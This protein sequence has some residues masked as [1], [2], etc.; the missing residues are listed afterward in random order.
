M[1][2]ILAG[3]TIFSPLAFLILVVL[4]LDV[5]KTKKSSCRIKITNLTKKDTIEEAYKFDDILS[6]YDVISRLPLTNDVNLYS[7]VSIDN[8][9]VITA[10]DR[11]QKIIGYIG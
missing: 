6:P 7:V 4:R 3:I 9:F 2:F 10:K 5:N 8:R 1:D 11:K